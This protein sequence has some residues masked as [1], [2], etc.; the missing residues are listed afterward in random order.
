MN[1]ELWSKE[2][3]ESGRVV[4]VFPLWDEEPTLCEMTDAGL[5]PSTTGLELETPMYGGGASIKLEF[6][7]DKYTR[8][9]YV[10]DTPDWCAVWEAENK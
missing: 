3:P 1:L 4:L 2:K 5:V 8:W 6:T 9:C 10:P 7:V